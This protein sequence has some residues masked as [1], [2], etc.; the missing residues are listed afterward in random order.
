MA[1]NWIGDYIN[2]QIEAPQKAIRD[3]LDAEMKMRDAQTEATIRIEQRKAT[4][5]IKILRQHFADANSLYLKD[6]ANYQAAMKVEVQ[7]VKDAFDKIMQMRNKLTQE[8]AAAADAAAKKAIAN[9][10]QVA[11]NKEKIQDRTFNTDLQTRNLSPEWQMRMEEE[12]MRI[13]IWP[14]TPSQPPK[15]LMN[16]RSPTRNGG[17][18]RLTARWLNRPRSRAKAC[19]SNVRLLKT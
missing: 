2:Q 4:D 10:M 6:V 5:T 12:R 15:T 16:R 11:E 17:G 3:A 19:S 18:P 8:L 14:R 13:A 9:D 1:G 7:S